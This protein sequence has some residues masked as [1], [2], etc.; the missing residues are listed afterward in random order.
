M[1]NKAMLA[2][3][4]AI[5][6]GCTT[7]KP[8]FLPD[9]RQGFSIRCDGAGLSWENCFSKASEICQA[10]GYDVFSQNGDSSTIVTATPTLVTAAPVTRRILLIGCRA[11]VSE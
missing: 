8:M 1:K 10:R 2:A 4:A 9:G 3:V 7:A 11:P 5:V 6:S